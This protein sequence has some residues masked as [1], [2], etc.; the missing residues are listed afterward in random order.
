M[1][2]IRSGRLCAHVEKWCQLGHSIQVR[3]KISTYVRIKQFGVQPFTRTLVQNCQV[4]V[5]WLL[6]I[7]TRIFL[8]KVNEIS[9]FMIMFFHLLNYLPNTH[10]FNRLLMEALRKKGR[11]QYDYRSMCRS[12]IVWVYSNRFETFRLHNFKW[13]SFVGY[14][15]RHQNVIRFS[16][17]LRSYPL[18]LLH[19]P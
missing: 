7:L 10:S 5:K 1:A 2:C 11:V 18:C 17:K 12:I 3:R 4:S 15:L 16:R 14:E 8:L 13:L 9:I 19:G 6:Y